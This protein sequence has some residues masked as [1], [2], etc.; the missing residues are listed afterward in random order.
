MREIAEPIPHQVE[1]APS[2]MQNS[3]AESGNGSGG[4]AFLKPGIARVIVSSAEAQ[5]EP[6][7]RQIS[8]EARGAPGG[9]AGL[10][11]HPNDLVY[12][13]EGTDAT[14]RSSKWET[15]SAIRALVG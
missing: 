3:K 10:T 9:S 7:R 4:R 2:E 5:R 15:D 12:P 1:L 13:L 8:P 6:R 11:A 14:Q